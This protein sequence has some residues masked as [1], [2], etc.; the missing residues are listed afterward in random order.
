MRR[1]LVALALSAAACAGRRA[2][3]PFEAEVP[4]AE[5]ARRADELRGR[6][7]LTRGWVVDADEGPAGITLEVVGSEEALVRRR[8]GRSAGGAAPGVPDGVVVVLPTAAAPGLTA[9]LQGRELELGL[10]ID[11]VH[12]LADGRRALDAFPVQ[13]TMGFTPAA[14]ET[15]VPPELR[16]RAEAAVTGG[17]RRQAEFFG[18]PRLPSGES[19]ETQ[20]RYRFLD[21][22]LARPRWVVPGPAS[23]A[24]G[25]DDAAPTYLFRTR[26]ASE[27]GERKESR[28]AFR[29]EQ[30]RLRSVGYDET[31]RAADG[32]V[33]EERHLDFLAGEALDR[34]SGRMFRWPANIYAAPCIGFALTGYPFDDTRVVSFFLWSE[35]DPFTT[36]YATLDGRET[37]TVPAGTFECYRVRMNANLEHIVR[38]LAL[39]SESAYDV[40]RGVVDRLRQPDTVLWFAVPWPHPFVRLEGPMGPP[41]TT[42]GAV[43]LVALDAGTRTALAEAADRTLDE[44]WA[45]PAA[46]AGRTVDLRFRIAASG[47]SNGGVWVEAARPG[48]AADRPRLFL[49]AGRRLGASGAEVELHGVVGA[50]MSLDT[51]ARAIIVRAR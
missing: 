11:G 5:V 31:V 24:R 26:V 7:V 18:D 35:L 16:A 41:G 50:L 19:R 2:S 47:E 39:P 28:C 23:I 42:R 13:V 48:R 15:P 3:Q 20:L 43:E 36:M 6:M 25:G 51:G 8:V 29:V 46:F 9:E 37:V 22:G 4:L 45:A 33:L 32:R 1:A 34:V 44:M 14:A 17:G 27:A 40:A 30:G 10:R 21:P 49:P 12:T 38:S